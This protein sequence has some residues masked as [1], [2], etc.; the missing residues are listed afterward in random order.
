MWRGD[1]GWMEVLGMEVR[2]EYD[3]I[4]GEVEADCAVVLV[5]C[6]EIAIGGLGKKP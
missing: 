1:Y 2:V 5:V 6:L 3:W 4:M